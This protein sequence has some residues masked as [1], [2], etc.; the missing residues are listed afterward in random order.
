MNLTSESID[1]RVKREERHLECV[2]QFAREKKKVFPMLDKAH[3]RYFLL[4]FFFFFLFS[5]FVI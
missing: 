2:W 4:L 3:I 1:R 5:F